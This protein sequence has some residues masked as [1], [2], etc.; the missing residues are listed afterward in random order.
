MDNLLFSVN[1]VLPLFLLIAVGALTKKVGLVKESFSEGANSLSFKLFLPVLLFN[2]IY[3]CD[4][5]MSVDPK[6]MIYAGIGS[7]ATVL[8]SLVVVYIFEKDNPKRGTL[9]QAMFRSNYLLFATPLCEAMFP[10]NG[11]AMASI[12]SI[13]IIPL[14]N[15]GAVVLLSIFGSKQK[16]NFKNTLISILKN[17]FM[18]ASTIALILV[19]TGIRL[20]QVVEKTLNNIAQVATPFALII[21][22]MDLKFGSIKGNLKQVIWGTLGKLVICPLV[23]LPTA[24]AMGFSGAPFAVLLSLYSAPTA[25]SSYAMAKGAGAD[26]ELAAQ[27]VVSTSFF[28]LFT[29]FFFVLISKQLG[30]V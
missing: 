26:H 12:L 23:M 16:A 19:F 9:M 2:N 5:S 8:L 21:L 30:L 14:Q 22:G 20:P 17:P 1:I 25:V 10:E 7:T 27:L 4:L 18:I 6:L 11:A 15:I 13:I 29:V 24:I 28:S 3:H